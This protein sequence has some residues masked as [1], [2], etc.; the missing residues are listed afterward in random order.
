[1]TS[2]EVFDMYFVVLGFGGQYLA[3]QLRR[4]ALRPVLLIARVLKYLKKWLLHDMAWEGL[5]TCK[6]ITWGVAVIRLAF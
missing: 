2:L 5:A 3:I 1:M 4:A 6:T